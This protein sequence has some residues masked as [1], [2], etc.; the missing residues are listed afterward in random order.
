MSSFRPRFSP[1]S[2]WLE[3]WIRGGMNHE[4][5]IMNSHPLQI[6]LVF[7]ICSACCASALAQLSPCPGNAIFE[8]GQSL[9][10]GFTV[11]LGDLDDDG[12]LDA[13]LDPILGSGIS[14]LLNDGQGT[15]SQNG[16]T[17][18]QYY[19]TALAL[20]DL[21][22]DEDLD[23]FQGNSLGQPDRVYLNDGNAV[24]TDSGQALGDSDNHGVTLGDMDGDGDLD[25]IVVSRDGG[26]NEFQLFLN[27]GSGV[28][29][30]SG[31]DL[32]NVES[33][34]VALGDLDGDGDLDAFFG[35]HLTFNR[36]YLNDGS[37]TLIDTGQWVTGG[38][39]GNS[40]SIDLGDVDGDGD[41]DA[42]LSSFTANRVY[43]NDGTGYFV[44][45]GQQLGN[46]MS[47]GVVLGDLDGDD[48]LD[49]FVANGNTDSNRIYLN[50]G[51]GL[52]V[53][54]GV[55]VGGTNMSH[56]A[57]LGDLDGDGDLDAIAAAMGG[58]VGS[59]VYMNR[60]AAR[61]FRRGECNGDTN[62]NFGDVLFLLDYLFKSNQTLSCQ[63]AADVNDDGSNNIIDVF[64]LL[65][66]FFNGAVAPPVP[67]NSCGFDPTDDD[68]DC[69]QFV[70]CP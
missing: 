4:R 32:G 34:S 15:F 17:G 19:T 35:R 61:P 44:D 49:A 62:I 31:Q 40:H 41:L 30:D 10:I 18:P 29:T 47:F 59:T 55:Q 56:A 1:L 70:G 51:T 22:G 21:D 23:I 65:V 42:F 25:A 37:G 28:F 52:F 53:D 14:I 20:G 11:A 6:L 64:S 60:C 24:F 67:F 57:V 16:Q 5:S 63:D 8:V 66:Y 7:S 69:E 9:D 12:D 43:L 3:A 46:S 2:R 54:S 68:L 27:D 48:D 36:V 45:S 13:V 38:L 58:N 33:Y 50:E 39:W 26:L